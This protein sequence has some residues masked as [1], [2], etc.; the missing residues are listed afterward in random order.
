MNIKELKKLVIDE[1]SD[2]DTQEKYIR[3]A[4]KGLWDKESELIKQFFIQKG[5]ILDIGC[6]TGRTTI[7]LIKKGYDVVGID[8]TPNMIKNAKKIAVNKKL[9]IN[10]NV[11]DATNLKF[12]DNSFDYAL[13]SNQGW[14]QIPG[15]NNRLKALKEVHRVLKDEGIFIFTFHKRSFLGK[16]IFFW[17]WKSIRYYILKPLRFPIDEIDFGDRFFKR[18]TKTKQFIHIPSVKKVKEQIIKSGFNL[19]YKRKG[20]NDQSGSYPIFMVCKKK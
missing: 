8:I 13:F 10:Y 4:N 6:G 15:E 18:E 5:K 19:I 17:I 12:K 16:Y 11:G 7:S 3:Y 14:S 2:K 20:L 9:K 1:F